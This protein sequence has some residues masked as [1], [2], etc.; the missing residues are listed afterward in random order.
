MSSRNPALASRGA[1]PGLR[2]MI[3]Q[4][5]VADLRRRAERR[6]RGARA[7]GG[8]LKRVGA[9]YRLPSGSWV[10]GHRDSS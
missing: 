3:A 8:S 1:Y 2:L 10:Y 7:N 4:Q 5:R 6:P 9:S